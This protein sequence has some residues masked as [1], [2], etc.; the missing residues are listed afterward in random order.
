MPSIDPPND[1]ISPYIRFGK[2]GMY[3]DESAPEVIRKEA[4]QYISDVESVQ[5]MAYG[6]RR[7]MQ[8]IDLSDFEGWKR[9][10]E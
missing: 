6:D 5:E 1:R 7:E 10:W 2:N 3:V 9:K 8:L 4:E